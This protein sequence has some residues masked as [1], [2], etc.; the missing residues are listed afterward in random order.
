MQ[1]L[2]LTPAETWAAAPADRPFAPASLET[3][4]FVH[5]THTETE[6]L[7]AGDRHLRMDPRPYVA[8]LVDLGRLTVPWR[9]DGDDRFPHAYG[10]LDR[11][12][13]TEVR[14]VRR[15]ADGTFRSLDAPR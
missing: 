14:G 2:H 15:D 7:A 12:A 6:L 9:Y 8:L 5:L 4:G 10:P 13:I 11:G 3:E 1:A